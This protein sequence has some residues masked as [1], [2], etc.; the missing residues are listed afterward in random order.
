M[1]LSKSTQSFKEQLSFKERESVDISHKTS[2]KLSILLTR[3]KEMN[4][5]YRQHSLA[6][7]NWDLN[8]KQSGC[9]RG[10]LIH[11][12]LNVCKTVY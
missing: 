2:W 5:Q 6:F 7:P 1:C 10:C 3:L 12:C 9:W 4:R 11:T 8:H